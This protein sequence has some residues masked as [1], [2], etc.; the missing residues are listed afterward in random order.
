MNK[1]KVLIALVVLLMVSLFALKHKIHECI[2]Y[3]YWIRDYL[4]NCKCI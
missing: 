2:R 4:L 1:N 3:E